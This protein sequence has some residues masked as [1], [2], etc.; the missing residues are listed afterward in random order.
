MDWYAMWIFIVDTMLRINWQM[1]LFPKIMTSILHFKFQLIRFTREILNPPIYFLS[2]LIRN[3][4]SAIILP[5]T[6]N[7]FME[8]LSQTI[9]AVETQRIGCTK[10]KLRGLRFSLVL[11]PCDC[12]RARHLDMSLC[13]I[14]ICGFQD[15]ST[16]KDLIERGIVPLYDF[17]ALWSFCIY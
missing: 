16:W 10:N 6:E 13:S 11:H 12:S 7:S 9:S 4:W 2:M 1:D 3:V 17:L 15:P 5:P 14:G 8:L